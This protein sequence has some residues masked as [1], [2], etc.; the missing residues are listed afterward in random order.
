MVGIYI[1]S[2][3]FQICIYLSFSLRSCSLSDAEY[4]ALIIFFENLNK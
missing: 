1:L 4:N 3:A 2:L